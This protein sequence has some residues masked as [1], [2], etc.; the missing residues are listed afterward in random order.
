MRLTLELSG[1]LRS[2][3]AD[4]KPHNATPLVTVLGRSR[5]WQS[6]A[7]VVTFSDSGDAPT[8]A[9]E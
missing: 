9:L 2:D 5:R 8:S 3:A 7:L 1:R 6:L 4:S